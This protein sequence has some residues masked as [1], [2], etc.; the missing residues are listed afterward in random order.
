[1]GVYHHVAI[2]GIVTRTTHNYV[3]VQDETAGIMLFSRDWYGEFLA[4][5]FNA[6]VANGEIQVGDELKVAGVVWDFNG[7]HE[8]T[9]MHAWEVVS[10]G[11]QLPPAQVVDIA[12]YSTNGEEYESEIVRVEYV[13]ILDPVDSLFG[14]YIYEIT[15][16]DESQIGWMSIQ[17]GGNS[18]WAGM[19]APQWILQS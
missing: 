13:R 5:G 4:L 16:E 8:L 19:P 17:G 18:D 11:N 14:G 12:E 7:L 3:Y 10:T 9:R 15:N 6:A 1:M 2:Q